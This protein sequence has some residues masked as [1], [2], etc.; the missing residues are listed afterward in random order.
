VSDDVGRAREAM[1]KTVE[2]RAPSF[3]HEETAKKLAEDILKRALDE[4]PRDGEQVVLDD[5]AS[6]EVVLTAFTVCA[7]TLLATMGVDPIMFAERVISS[8]VSIEKAISA[9]K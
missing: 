4:F 7:A 2:R 5:G 8:T 6:A 9:E 3:Q 1:K